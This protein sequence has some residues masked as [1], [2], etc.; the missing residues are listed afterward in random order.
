M[1]SGATASVVV[2]LDVEVNSRVE[3]QVVKILSVAQVAVVDESAIAC[4]L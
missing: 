1:Q 4:A 3:D 2:E